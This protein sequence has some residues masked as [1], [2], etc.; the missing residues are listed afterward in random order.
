M[1]A[2]RTRI[3]ALSY[4]SFVLLGLVGTAVGPS[5][6]TLA[7]QMGVGLDTAGGLVSSLSMGYLFA[8]LIAGPLIDALGRRPIFLAAL[9]LQALSL[10][11]VLLAPRMALGMLAMFFLGLGQGSIDIAVH[12]VVGDTASQNR[13]AAL[14]RVHFF[15]GLGGLAGPVLAGQ[16]LSAL[17]S[18]WPA[19]VSFLSLNLMLFLGVAMTPLSPGQQARPTTRARPTTLLRSRVFWLAVSFFVLYVGLEVGIGTWTFTFLNKGLH[20]TVTLASWAAS[21]FY[22]ALTLGRLTAARLVDRRVTGER[23]VLI[24]LSGAAA[25]TALL[26]VGAEMSAITLFFAGVMLVGFCFGPIYPTAM[27][28]V[29]RRYP[30]AIGTAVGLITTSASVGAM[31][32]P[33]FQGWLLTN[34]GLS[35]SIGAALVG[36]VLL[37]GVGASLMRR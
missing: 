15:F 30:D 34:H 28:W 1:P 27:G 12:V 17:G 37:W 32:M 6:P 10:P 16:S 21:G 4:A 19:F 13:G 23:M 11:A 3:V 31:L 24:G 18:L 33:L 35:W 14:N 25:A 8:G 36:L 2:L 20:T 7:H 29:Q 5:L 22:L 26:W 9:G